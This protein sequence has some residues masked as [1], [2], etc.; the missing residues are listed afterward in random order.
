MTEQQAPAPDAGAALGAD[1]TALGGLPSAEQAALENHLGGVDAPRYRSYQF[2]LVAPHCGETILEVGA[3]LGEF[4]A[5]FR[6]RRRVV[7]TD[8]DPTCLTALTERFAAWPEFEV[9]PLDLRTAPA[10]DSRV[11]TVL[12]MNV[13]EHIPDDRAALR[14]MAGFVRSGGSV[15]LWVPAYP[16]LYGEFDRTVGHVRRYRPEELHRVVSDAGLRV[17][18]LHPVNLL[19]GLS[20]WLAVRTGRTSR[21]NTRLVRLY[22]RVVVP[23]ERAIEKV[24]SPPFGQSILCVGRVSS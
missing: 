5:Q 3:G 4:A 9:L 15:V 1:A 22:D 16:S 24:L 8:T 12:A 23:A 6:G 7:V 2:D 10:V 21:V 17:E 19:G 18:L 11:D 20:W 13:L 14:A